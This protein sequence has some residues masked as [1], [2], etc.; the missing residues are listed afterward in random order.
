MTIKYFIKNWRNIKEDIEF[1]EYEWIDISRHEYLEEEFI[2]KYQNKVDW[3]CVSKYQKLSEEFMKKYQ[4]KVDW[5]C[6][7]KCQKLSDVFIIKMNE[8]ID[9]HNLKYNK[10]I[11]HILYESILGMNLLIL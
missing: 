7:S 8:Y 6:V 4:N 1:T 11:K 9:Y 2:E 3:Y 5:Y 10:N